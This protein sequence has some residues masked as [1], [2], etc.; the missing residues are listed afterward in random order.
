ME[1]S[2]NLCKKCQ[3]LATRTTAK[4]AQFLL[5]ECAKRKLKFGLEV[6]FINGWQGSKEDK[7]VFNIVDVPVKCEQFEVM[8]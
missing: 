2:L 1:T 5:F 8:K 6:D 3:H 4:P 7:R